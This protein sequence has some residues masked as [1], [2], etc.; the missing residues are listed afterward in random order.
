MVPC[1]SL[2]YNAKE[3][4][5]LLKE[6]TVNDTKW[7]VEWIIIDPESFTGD[8]LKINCHLF[9]MIYFIFYTV[10]IQSCS[11]LMTFSVSDAV[12]TCREHVF[13]QA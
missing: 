13:N 10:Y 5:L 11:L 6:E 9:W 1:S 2:T 8:Q 4:R 12:Y 7:T 3:I